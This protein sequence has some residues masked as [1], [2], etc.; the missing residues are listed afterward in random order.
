MTSDKI[1]FEFFDLNMTKDLLKIRQEDDNDDA[2]LNGTIGIKADR[3]VKSQLFVYADSFP[4]DDELL[5]LA[6][7]A[8][9]S[10][11]V[12]KYKRHNNNRDA[13][14]DHLEDAKEEIAT[15]AMR[16]KA[17][18]TTRT[19]IVARSQNYDTED[20]PLFSQRIIR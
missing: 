5:E 13:S 18:P 7:G 10:Y 20:D 14:K 1:T 11:A 3:W 8:A 19:R 9:C 6:T 4:L 16:L 12:G 15:L 2:L 17:T